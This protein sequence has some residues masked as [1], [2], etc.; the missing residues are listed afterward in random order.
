MLL[1]LCNAMYSIIYSTMYVNMYIYKYISI[2]TYIYLSDRLA[3]DALDPVQRHRGPCRL[4]VRRS[5]DPVPRY[6][7]CVYVYV[8]V[9]V[10]MHIHVYIYIYIYIHTHTHTGTHIV[11]ASEDVVCVWQYSSK[12]SKLTSIEG[13]TD[14][15][16][17]KRKDAREV[18]KIYMYVCM[19]L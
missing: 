7:W 11:C 18:Y 5:R 14:S 13:K 3:G 2:Y 6:D 10:C 16:A 9:F 8:H 17:L 1:I 19:Y 12:V 15:I 4:Q